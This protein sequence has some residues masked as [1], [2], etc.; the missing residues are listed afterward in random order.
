M[1]KL[2]FAL[3][4]LYTFTVA[5]QALSFK[6]AAEQLHLSPSAVS[7]QIQSLESSLNVELFIRKN[8]ALQLT[9]AGRLLLVSARSSFDNLSETVETISPSVASQALR[10]SVLPYFANN[11]LLPR[12]SSF[13]SLHPNIQLS[14]DSDTAYKPFD[15][16]A[17]DGCF[18]FSPEQRDD[19]VAMKL[20]R[21][22]AIPVASSELLS[23]HDWAG[24]LKILSE[25]R[26]FEAAA[27]PDLWQQWQRAH[28]CEN[29]TPKDRL[30]FNDA[31]TALQAAREGLGVVMGA[32]PLIEKDIEQQRLICL[33]KPLVELSEIYYFVYS[34]DNRQ[35]ELLAMVEWLKQFQQET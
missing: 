26:W 21:Q 27:Q 33:T 2:P 10:L 16:R 6:A 35:P 15:S 34:K 12:L 5:A 31:E 20:F 11:W 32:W 13:T 18:R 1:K 19:L 24:D 3:N 4:T 7:R 8:R 23:Q 9:D 22:Y 30:S 17:V 28:H 25:L 29:L 14:F